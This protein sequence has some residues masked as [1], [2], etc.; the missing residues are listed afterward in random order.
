MRLLVTACPAAS[1]FHPLVPLAR[2]AR[3]AGHDVLVAVGGAFAPSAA[4]AGFA[5]HP[6]G[7]E[8]DLMSV[9][10]GP[11][12]SGWARMVALAERTAPEVIALARRWRPEAV[13]R[14]PPEFAGA[15]A[16]RAVGAALV[17]H[18][19]GLVMPRERMAAAERELSEL[20]AAHG[21]R[22]GLAEP[23]A[24]I[25][26]CPPSLRPAHLPTG[27]PMRYE[28]YD[29]E[30]AAAGGRDVDLCLTLGTILPRLG[31]TEVVR[32]VL[33]AAESLGLRTAVLGLEPGAAWTPL[34]GVLARCRV[35]AHHGGSGTTFSA[36]AAGVPQLVMP[37]MTDQPDNAALVAGTGVALAPDEVTAASA[38][39]ALSRLLTPAA[40]AAAHRVRDEIAAMPSP[41]ETAARLFG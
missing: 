19:F 26:L 41:E 21:V 22:G 36:L 4:A 3:A 13:L 18:S 15:L 2:A 38:R 27:V 11:G 40:L 32:P 29:G 16:A 10:G 24:L 33:A 35:L 25:D 7:G 1:H 5:V 9:P 14:T 8:I 28:P 20:S 39:R 37:H 23:D 34:S 31:R 6:V 30:P 17:E 12:R